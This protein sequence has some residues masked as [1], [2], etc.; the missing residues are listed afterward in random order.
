M[1]ASDDGAIVEPTQPTEPR[2]DHP[3]CFILEKV[4]PP[5]KSDLV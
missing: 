2:C 1:C 3:Q 5:T 4:N